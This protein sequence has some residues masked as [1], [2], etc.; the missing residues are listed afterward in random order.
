MG[1]WRRYIDKRK[2]QCWRH[3]DKYDCV[4]KR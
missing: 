1:T 4:R 3:K 2:L